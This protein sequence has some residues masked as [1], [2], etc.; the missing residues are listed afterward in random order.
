MGVPVNATLTE[1]RIAISEVFWD[2][3][4]IASRVIPLR[5]SHCAGEGIRFRSKRAIDRG[6]HQR[7][8]TFWRADERYSFGR[9]SGNNQ[10][11]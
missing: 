2:L 5:L 1:W 3:A 11:L 6:M 7:V 8:V 4:D 10:R 9:S